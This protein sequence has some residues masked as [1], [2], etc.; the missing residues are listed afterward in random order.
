MDIL[1]FSALT[2]L[3]Y[4][5]CGSLFIS[6]KINNFYNQFYTYFLG[7]IIISFISLVLNFFTPLTPLINSIFY[8][9]I[10]FASIFKK[11]FSLNKINII[12][13]IISSLV[14]FL[15][16]IYSTVNRPD[17]GLYHL[18]YISIINENKIIFG[19]SNIHFRFGHISILQY[20]SA[21]NNNYLFLENGISIPVASIVSFFYIYFFYDIYTVIKEKK[22]VNLSNFFSLFIIIYIAFKISRYSEFGND[23]VAHL[24]FFYLIQKLLKYNINKINFNRILLTS[25]FI[26]LNKPTLGII[27]IAPIIIF[28]IQNTFQLKKIFYLFISFPVFFFYL[29]LIK[30]IVI[31]G[32]A[33]YPMK[34]TCIENLPWINIKEVESISNMSEAWSKA[35][36]DKVNQNISIEE[37]NKNF[38]WLDAW[39]QKHLKFILNI[40]IP[41]I[42]V[43]LIIVLIIKIQTKNIIIES[44]KYNKKNFFLTFIITGIGI[45]SFFFLFPLY[46][47]GYSYIIS[48]ISLL[49]LFIIKDKI[50]VKE[51]L[52]IFKFIFITC[53][54]VIIS[55]QGIKIFKDHTNS[56]WPNIYTLDPNNKIYQKK[57]IKINEDFSYYLSENGDQLCMYKYAPCTSYLQKKL[58]Y[59][60]KRNYVFLTVN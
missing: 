10:I 11:K 4:F 59:S 13:L 7:A 41:Y 46:R 33:I 2:N 37:Y 50:L 14:T 22:R 12:F 16:I 56:I 45:L 58:K 9:L 55:K 31:S 54:T 39:S 26:F 43:L 30:N 27:F 18:P 48:F 6:N 1:I 44:Y 52:K 42:I 15:L 19:V 38:N 36:P 3:I 60:L 5:Y 51:N 40:I 49:F 8:F 57:K 34:I 53:L 35:W 21:I 17:A 23:A 47:Y 24:S 25:V 20:L 28:F 32:C 29:W